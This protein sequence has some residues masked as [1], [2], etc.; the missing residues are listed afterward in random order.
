[1]QWIWSGL[2]KLNILFVS[3]QTLDFITQYLLKMTWDLSLSETLEAIYFLS[4]FS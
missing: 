1:M 4:K 2:N 3:P